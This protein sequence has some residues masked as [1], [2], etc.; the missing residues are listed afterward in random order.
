MN[1]V[2]ALHPDTTLGPVTIRVADLDRSLRFYQEILGF[3]PTADGNGV[4]ALGA[5]GSPVVFLKQVPGARAMRRSSGLYHFAVVVP[6]RP[7][8]G[9][10]LRRLAEAEIGIGEADHLVS[11]A[12]YLSDPDGNGIEIYRDRPRSEWKWSNGSVQMATEPLDLEGLLKEGDR[13]PS[14]SRLFPDGTRIGHVHLQVA[15]VEQAVGFYHGAVGFDVTAAL[16]G[17]AFLSAGGY[18]HHLGLNS[19][20][21]RGAPAA[22]DG[23]TGLESFV[24]HVPD[25]E[26]QDGVAR[27]LQAAGV[28][29]G[30]EDGILRVRDPWNVEVLVTR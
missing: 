20:A 23:S 4:A 10:A 17:A 9:Q 16:P 21:S 19:W 1:P 5:G 27:R 12:L 25:A 7:A 18:H 14:G 28:A 30:M 2:P 24:I 8:L 29:T 22:P 3:R 11:E 13:D 26:A 6:S 15:D